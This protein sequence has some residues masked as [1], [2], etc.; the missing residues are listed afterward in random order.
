MKQALGVFLGTKEGQE[1]LQ[2]NEI[3]KNALIAQKQ[4][5]PTGYLGGGDLSKMEIPLEGNIPLPQAPSSPPSIFSSGLGKNIQQTL[6]LT[7]ADTGQSSSKAKINYQ[8]AFGENLLGNNI[9]ELM[10]GE[11]GGKPFIANGGKAGQLVDTSKIRTLG[12]LV[13]YQSLPKGSFER[14]F[15]YGIFQT[16]PGFTP[17]YAKA[18]G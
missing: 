17:G 4:Q 12:D 3:W 13:R 5:V 11:S 1:A 16:T 15:A 18:R 7:L 6:G 10:S 8:Q 14:V 2:Q 9:L